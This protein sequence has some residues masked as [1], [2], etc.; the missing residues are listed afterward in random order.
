MP[1]QALRDIVKKWVDE[2]PR[3]VDEL[4]EHYLSRFKA[5]YPDTD[6]SLAY[7]NVVSAEKRGSGRYKSVGG[8]SAQQIREWIMANPMK[9]HE[10]VT[11]YYSRCEIDCKLSLFQYALRYKPNSDYTRREN[12]L[13]A[14]PPKRGT[15]YREG[16]EVEIYTDYVN[17]KGY[18]G[19]AIC[20]EYLDRAQ[21]V[22]IGGKFVTVEIWVVQ[23]EGGFEARRKLLCN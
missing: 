22:I 9:D 12:P 13:N 1:K 19:K 21:P 15:I 11:D 23:F 3:D 14:L 8:G 16:E 20:V 17:K 6:I 7:F 2:N 10:Q 18:E 4:R 5:A